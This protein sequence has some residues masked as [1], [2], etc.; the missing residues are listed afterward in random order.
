M[1]KNTSK[2]YMDSKEEQER[3]RV[4]RDA[5]HSPKL[6]TVGFQCR[7]GQCEAGCGGGNENGRRLFGRLDDV[8]VAGRL[9]E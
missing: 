3:R 1:A 2:K 5:Q 6:F 7:F 4:G 8:K 9:S